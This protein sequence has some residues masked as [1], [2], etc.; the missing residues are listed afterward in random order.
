MSVQS[1]GGKTGQADMIV[2]DE[3]LQGLG[4]EDAVARWYRGAMCVVKKLRFL[5][6]YASS[7]NCTTG[8]ASATSRSC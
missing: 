2:L 5:L 1:A 7:N 6:S 8:Q 4:L 3:Q